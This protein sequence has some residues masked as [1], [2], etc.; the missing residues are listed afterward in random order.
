VERI[1]KPKFSNTLNYRVNAMEL[2]IDFGAFFPTPGKDTQAPTEADFHTRIVM[3]AD[4][5]DPF[6][7]ALQELKKSRDKARELLKPTSQ[8]ADEF[9]KGSTQ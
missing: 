4:V 8:K 1:V 7:N 9:S 5:I 2:I 3:G 6:I